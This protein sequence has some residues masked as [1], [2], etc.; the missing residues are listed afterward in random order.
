MPIS[1]EDF[2]RVGRTLAGTVSV[3][4]THENDGEAIKGLTVSTFATL[5]ID[6]PLVMFAIQHDAN[7]Y[8]VIMSCRNFG[9]SVLGATQSGIAARFAV[10]S[11]NK[12]VGIRFETGQKLRVPL[13]ADAVA[14]IECETNQIFIGGDHAIIVGLVAAARTRDAAPLLYFGRTYGTFVELPPS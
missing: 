9:V 3:V 12:A 5:S 7:S 8:P 13:I 4:T 6:P 11:D 2:R 14:Q 1:K 10:K